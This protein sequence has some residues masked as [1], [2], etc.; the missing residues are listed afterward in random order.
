MP[1]SSR[2]NFLL[3]GLAVP[4]AASAA[5]S[6][7]DDQKQAAP[8]RAAIASPQLRYRVLGETGLRV[9]SVGFGCMVTSDGSVIE[10]AADIG[11]TYFDTAR[12]YQ[13]GNNERMVG[14]A[15][16]GKRQNITLSS[17]THSATKEA[18]LA[19]LDTSLRELGTDHLDI[20]YLHAKEKPADVTDE[21][22]DAQQTAKKAGKIRFAGVST[23]KGQAELIPALI[24]NPHIDVILTAY[25][26]SMGQ[27]LDPVIAAAHAAGKGVVAMKVMAGG[28]RLA[29]PG[30]KLY[31]T[32]K[33]D[34][35]L[36]SA[37]R[38][39]LKSS[40]IDT[41]IPSIT[42][43]DQLEENLKA[44][45][46]GFARS[47]ETL[48]ARHLERIAPLY[49]RMCGQCDGACAKGLPVADILRCLTYADGYG[50]F[51]LGRERFLELPAEVA[52]VRCDSCSTCT[53]DCPHGVRVSERLARA[54]ELFA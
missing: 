46:G 16:K 17:K 34:G 45:T 23:H 26:F 1:D 12:G 2:R 43:L 11:I 33:K 52:Q 28:L 50:Q 47:D 48:L 54:Q 39:V 41:T 44:M 53:V 13:G 42:D 32:F 38:W 5:R 9:T 36:L 40:D 14:A 19:D 10:R 22:I 25:N 51:S 31:D 4:A 29:K 24:A 49:C 3:T 6:S 8:P 7:A 30:N 18:A 21:L 35:A 15:L 20:W 37:L 27:T